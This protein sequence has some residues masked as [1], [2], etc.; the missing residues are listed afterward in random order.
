M[1]KPM[2]RGAK[3]SGRAQRVPARNDNL[4]MVNGNYVIQV[5]ERWSW[6][7]EVLLFNL[8]PA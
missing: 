2:C 8:W 7:R 6:R 3:F 4:R 5:L 1:I